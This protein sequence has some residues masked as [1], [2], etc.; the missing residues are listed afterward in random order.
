M[1][2]G[3]GISKGG[4]ILDLAVPRKSSFKERSLV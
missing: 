4:A 3:E 1:L 2:Y